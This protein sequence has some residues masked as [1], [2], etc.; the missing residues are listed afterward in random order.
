MHG[1]R[2]QHC[3]RTSAL[4]QKMLLERLRV[5]RAGGPRALRLKL[6]R[7]RCSQTDTINCLNSRHRTR[8]I[9]RL[10]ML[11]KWTLT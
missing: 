1:K 10:L 2:M 9:C 3:C 6:S 7:L 5:R 4:R 11:H 8:Y